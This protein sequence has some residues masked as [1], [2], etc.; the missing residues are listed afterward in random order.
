MRRRVVFPLPLRSENGPAVLNHLLLPE[1]PEAY[2]PGIVHGSL[3][4]F[5]LAGEYAQ[6]GGLSAAIEIGKRSSR[7]QPSAPAGDTRSVY[8]WHSARFPYRIPSGR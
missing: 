2:T 7:A 8:P 5:H 1:I 3:I 4:G 6:E